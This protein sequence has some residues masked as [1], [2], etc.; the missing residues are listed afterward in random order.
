MTVSVRK[1]TINIR[2][3][4]SAL[5]KPTGTF[6]E[7]LMRT[8]NISD[9]YDVVGTNRNIVINGDMSVSQRGTYTTATT[10]PA[11]TYLL[12]RWKMVPI[13]GVHTMQHNLNQVIVPGLRANTCKIVTTTTGSGGGW[14]IEQFI[15]SPSLYAGSTFTLSCWYKSNFDSYFNFYDGANQ[16]Q[17]L[18]PSTGN[19]WKKF[20]CTYTMPVGATEFR[21]EFYPHV[22]NPVVGNSFEFT[23]VQLERGTVATPFEHRPIQ[24]ELSLCQRYCYVDSSY[25]FNY[26][27]FAIGNVFSETGTSIVRFFP[28]TM[29]ASPSIA[30][31]SGT[32]FILDCGGIT[33]GT[34]SVYGAIALPT[35]VR[36]VATASGGLVAG[37]SVQLVNDATGITRTIIYSAEL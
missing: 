29:R 17:F 34:T 22:S 1:P 18:M 7:Q 6:G 31:S 27:T 20:S 30:V 37:Q 3:E 24:Q 21:L 36:L 4:L 10:F 9:F 14:A 2:E 16:P 11:I 26:A 5:K 25:G 28:V 33:A 35:H 23:L 15:E 32:G 13:G 12:D 8:A 19:L